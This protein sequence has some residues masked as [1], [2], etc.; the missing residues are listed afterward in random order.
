M[1]QFCKL[2]ASGSRKR[3]RAWQLYGALRNWTF[4]NDAA[5]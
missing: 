3:A 4:V 1:L 5:G 2:A